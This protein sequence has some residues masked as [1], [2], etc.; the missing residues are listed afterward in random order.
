MATTA[1]TE[2]WQWKFGREGLTFDDVLLIPAESSILPGEANTATRLTAEIALNIPI[3]SAAM[4]TV[5]EARLAIALAREGGFGVIHR[6]LSVADQAVEVD[7]VKRSES[8]MITDP[9]TLSPDDTLQSALDVMS[10][11]HISGIP[12]TEN[13]RLVGILTNRDLRFTRNADLGRPIGELMTRE[14]L[15]TAPV[16]TTLEE[17]RDILHRYKVEKLPVV[18]EHGRLKGLI[19]VKDIQKKQQYPLAAKDAQGRL[20]TGAAVGVGPDALERCEALVAEEVD[21]LVVDTA[22]GHSRMVLDTVRRIADAFGKRTQ[23]IVGNVATA[24]AT[25]ALI[26]A[27]AHAI[28]VGVGPG[29]FAAGTRI[30]LA[31][32]LYKNIEDMQAGDR[33]INMHGEPVTVVKAWQTG[34]REVMAIRHTASYRETL[35]TPDHRFL[36]GNLS[37]VGVATRAARGYVRTLERPTKRGISKIGWQEIG[38]AEQATLLTPRRIVFELPAALEIDLREFAVRQEKQ[39]ARYKTQ[40]S[41]SYELGYVF[42]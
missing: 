12:I 15:I 24:G 32:G 23:I 19:T 3:L 7:K 10:R 6:N 21:A 35:A 20:R 11:Y 37:T 1:T 5:T 34:V 40:I 14:G 8:G 29:C 33:V 13:G 26:D 25:E 36:T 2:E 27:G 31:N 22:H 41:S 17:A 16:G 9:I 42:G 38:V 30:L 18:D 39:L 4:D 28:K